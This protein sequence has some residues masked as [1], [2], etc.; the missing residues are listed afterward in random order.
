MFNVNVKS[1]YLIRIMII[2]TFKVIIKCV[3]PIA[4]PRVFLPLLRKL[5][6][7][8]FSTLTLYIDSG[9]ILPVI[10]IPFTLL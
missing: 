4:Q 2:Q 1:K 5:K 8:H 3:I 9:N 10:L 7:T 6:M